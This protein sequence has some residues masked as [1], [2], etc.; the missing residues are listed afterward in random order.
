MQGKFTTLSYCA[1]DPKK[2]ETI[3]VNGLEFNAFANLG[4]AL[5]QIRHFWK[6]KHDTQ[7]LLLWTDQ[8]CINQSNSDERSHQ[9]NFMG[10]IYGSAIQV[11][12]CLSAEGD[13][14]GGIRWLQQFAHE[15]REYEQN[16]PNSECASDS[17]ESED[18]GLNFFRENYDG[19]SFHCGWDACVATILKSPWWSRAWIRQ[20]YL[21]SSDVYFIAANESAHWEAITEAVEVFYNAAYGI[22]LFWDEEDRRTCPGSCQ[23]SPDACQ[24]CLHAMDCSEFQ[25]A[26]KRASTLLQL[27]TELVTKISYSPDLLDRLKHMHLCESSDPRDLVYSCFGISSE[28]YGLYPDYTSSVSLQDV[29]IKVA[30]NA[31]THCR[32]LNILRRAYLTRMGSSRSDLPS[33]VPD[34]RN[35]SRTQEGHGHALPSRSTD[36]FTFHPDSGGRPDRI[37]QVRGTQIGFIGEKEDMWSKVISCPDGRVPLVGYA[38]RNDE[39]YVLHGLGNLFL[40]RRQNDYFRVVGEVLGRDG[41]LPGVDLLVNGLEEMIERNDP[42]VLFI[43]IC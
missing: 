41:I 26:G 14:S 25:Y 16:Q 17:G 39:V 23:R 22:D 21:R 2:T 12:V 37:L 33:W 5:R 35:I 43:D 42:A 1:G 29:F 3:V 13:R 10:D 8:V 4:H 7:E 30:Q 32:S 34:W 15:F 28:S 9:V 31:M 11:L 27:K 19:E 20:E 36:F 24:A 38:K 18:H 40:L 6:E